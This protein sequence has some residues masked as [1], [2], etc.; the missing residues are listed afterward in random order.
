LAD[1]RF[2]FILGLDFHSAF[3]VAKVRFLTGFHEGLH[4]QP[5][6][7]ARTYASFLAPKL[8]RPLSIRWLSHYHFAVFPKFVDLEIYQTGIFTLLPSAVGL[9]ADWHNFA[10]KNG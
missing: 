1:K 4:K 5:F 9:F 2:Y 10:S 6:D 8:F 7:L 3:R